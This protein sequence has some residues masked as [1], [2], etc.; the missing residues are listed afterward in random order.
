MALCPSLGAS[1]DHT[2]GFRYN[3][4]SCRELGGIPGGIQRL[5]VRAS[6]VCTTKPLFILKQSHFLPFQRVQPV[7]VGYL[8]DQKPLFLPTQS[9]GASQDRSKKHRKLDSWYANAWNLGLRSSTI[10]P[11]ESNTCFRMV[12]FWRS[13]ARWGPGKL[14]FYSKKV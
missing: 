12:W 3:E 6:M 2:G 8:W 1:L 14:V 9:T 5:P 11:G 4:A 13:R 7:K 10:F